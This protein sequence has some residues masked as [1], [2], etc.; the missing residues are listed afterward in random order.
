MAQH[1]SLKMSGARRRIAMVEAQGAVD[2]VQQ[3]LCEPA[4]LRIV[5]ALD[6]AELT[7]SELA[8]AIERKVPATSQ[9]LRLLRRLGIVAGERHGT[10]IR[11]RLSSGE[12]TD[13][14][15][16]VLAALQHQESAAS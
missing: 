14:I 6:G 2:R 4:R 11:Y 10:T 15:Q 1:E 9:H 7:V 3:V 5:A 16:S 13:R 8:A 12:A